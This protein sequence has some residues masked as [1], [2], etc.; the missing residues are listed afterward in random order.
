MSLHLVSGLNGATLDL[1]NP[2]DEIAL[3]GV[4]QG[5]VWQDQLGG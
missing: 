2:G 3:D 1:P 5:G 4:G